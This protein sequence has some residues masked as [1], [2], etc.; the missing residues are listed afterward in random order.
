MASTVTIILLL[1]LAG[2]AFYLFRRFENLPNKKKK[3]FF[4]K[5]VN[6]VFH[7]FE[8]VGLMR[9]TPAY[10]RDYHRTFPGLAELEAGHGAVKAECLELLGIKDKLTDMRDLGAGYTAGGIHKAQWK[11][12]MFASGGR[13]IDE[14]CERAPKTTALLK[15]IPNMDTAF[16]S[17]LDPNQY[18]T[19]HWGYYKGYL[20]YHLG[21]VIP[22]NNANERCWLR[23]N[24]DVADNASQEK[25][26]IERGEKYHWHEGEG[27]IFDDNYLHDAA[28]ESDEVRVVLWLD[29][30]RP[31]PFYADVFNRFVLWFVGRDASVEKIR[32]KA[33]VGT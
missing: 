30:R 33:A 10:D 31:M 27:I 9:R 8:D 19:P 18:I 3:K 11:V 4:T 21:V 23:V 7:W 17:V 26:R 6:K 16:L 32:R 13:F 25:E 22:E 5:T 29:M 2:G 1:A 28:N 15:R 20:R 14:N 12:F 24:D